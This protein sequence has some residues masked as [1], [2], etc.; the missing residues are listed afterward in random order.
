MAKYMCT[1]TMQGISRDQFSGV[2]AAAQQD[3]VVKLLQ[4]FASL[5]EGKIFC[6]WQSPN[7]EVVAA[8]FQKM[9]VPYDSITKIEVEAVGGDVKTA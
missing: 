9:N 4:S 3:P 8:W 1:H 2:A 7:P 5:T 6:V